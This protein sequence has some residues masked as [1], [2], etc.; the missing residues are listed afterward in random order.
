MSA[1]RQGKHVVVNAVLTRDHT[2]DFGHEALDRSDG[3]TL[4]LVLDVSDD[5]FNLQRKTTE[6]D[7][8]TNKAEEAQLKPEGAHVT[9]LLH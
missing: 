4:C 3:H 8:G 2:G 5:V 1:R 6:E 9:N 7:R